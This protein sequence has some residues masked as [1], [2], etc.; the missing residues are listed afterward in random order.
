MSQA[1]KDRMNQRIRQSIVQYIQTNGPTDSRDIIKRYS[2]LYR[3]T[4]Q[5]ISGN[6]SAL[7]CKSG[8]LSII[9][10]MPHSIIYI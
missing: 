8:N 4:K 2:L 5:R 10:N 3:T 7:V 6:I 9:R 1:A